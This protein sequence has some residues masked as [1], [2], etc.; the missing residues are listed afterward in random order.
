MGFDTIRFKLKNLE[1]YEGIAHALSSGSK[2]TIG[3]MKYTK[4]ESKFGEVKE[5]NVVIAKLSSASYDINYFIDM[6]SKSA[7]FE[8]SVPKYIYGN[9]LSEFPNQRGNEYHDLLI[10]LIDFFN[11]EF[12]LPINLTDI[13]ILRIDI[14]YNYHFKTEENK[15][16]YKNHLE[17]IFKSH[18]KEHSTISYSQHNTV[19]YKTQDY[20]F[21]I[22]D[23]GEEFLKHDF[24]KIM[25]VKGREY[26]TKLLIE[27]RKIMRCEITYRKRKISYDFFS[28]LNRTNQ[29]SLT[30][31]QYFKVLKK[32]YNNCQ[33]ILDK[34]TLR[35]N[36]FIFKD[37]PDLKTELL[38]VVNTKSNQYHKYSNVPL[39][40]FIKT[41]ETLKA[42]YGKETKPYTSADLFHT[43]L[44]KEYKD[45]VGKY[46]TITAPKPI[47]LDLSRV[48]KAWIKRSQPDIIQFD[49]T[50]CRMLFEKFEKIVTDLHSFKAS[51]LSPLMALHVYRNELENSGIRLSNIKKYLEL[52]KKHPDKILQKKGIYDKYSLGRIKK[53]LVLIDEIIKNKN[54]ESTIFTIKLPEKIDYSKTFKEQNTVKEK[55]T[56]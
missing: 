50:L 17:Y 30:F 6:T 55:L 43:I 40:L 56:A 19:M 31:K 24:S 38:K 26:A 2:I 36:N 3:G 10:F 51:N 46:R 44:K 23:K 13:E 39:D 52:S 48:Q 53:K 34:L 9:N 35:T 42:K 28:Q 21:K 41:V 22:Y 33:S 7:T 27:S 32:D 49:E 20:S 11:L 15:N 54:P 25:K 5:D 16:L 37:K 47:L 29:V 18:F 14:C 12:K 8:F 45:R 1:N 4:R